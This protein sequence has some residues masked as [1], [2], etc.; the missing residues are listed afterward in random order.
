MSERYHDRMISPPAGVAP[1]VAW[2]REGNRLIPVAALVRPHLAE[3]PLPTGSETTRPD[4][5]HE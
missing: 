2:V 5:G 4:E 3:H 1:Q